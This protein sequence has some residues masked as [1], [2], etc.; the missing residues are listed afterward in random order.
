MQD[1]PAQPGDIAVRTEDFTFA[2][3]DLD[4]TAGTI[5]VHVT[6]TDSTRHTFT[7]DGLIDVSVAPNSTQRTTFKALPVPI[8]SIASRT[9]RT[10][11]ASSS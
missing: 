6:N 9:P 5:A 10:W 2:P 7:I 1:V 4:A 8:A 3:A 11:T